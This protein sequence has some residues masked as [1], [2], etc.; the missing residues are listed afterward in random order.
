MSY[1]LNN[2]HEIRELVWQKIGLKAGIYE[3]KKTNNNKLNYKKVILKANNKEYDHNTSIQKMVEHGVHPIDAIIHPIIY[4]YLSEHTHPNMIGSG[5][6]RTKDNKHYEVGREIL[7]IEVVYFAVY[8]SFLIGGEIYLYHT[9]NFD[10]VDTL[11][12]E[13]SRK[14]VEEIVEI[15]ELVNEISEVIVFDLNTELKE[16]IEKRLASIDIS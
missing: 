8:I 7:H 12:G 3:F 14:M 11:T 2:P 10:E 13:E 6:Y 4:P 1:I 5:N 15:R 16:L 9:A